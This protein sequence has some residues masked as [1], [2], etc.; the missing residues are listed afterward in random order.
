[1][2][3]EIKKKL[4]LI[5]DSSCDLPIEILKQYDITI[6]PIS[7][8]FDEE[9]RKPYIDITL[10]E[11]LNRMVE[12]KVVPI[13][14]VPPPIRFQDAFVK[15]LDKYEEAIM[16]TASKNLSGVWENA[17]IHAKQMTGNKVT[18]ID[19]RTSTH[20]FGLITLKA[21]RMIEDDLSKD[22]I[23]NKLTNEI[24]PKARLHAYMGT[25]EFLKRSGRIDNLKHMFG[26]LFKVKPL[27]T[28]ENGEITSNKRVR[29]EGAIIKY[30][31]QLGE[32]L[33]NAL[34]ETEQLVVTHSR[35]MEKAKELVYYM[36]EKSNKNLEIHI[37]EIGP[38]TG[39]HIGPGFLGLSW[40]GPAAED[41]FI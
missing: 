6:V 14:G 8:F 23:I 5:T 41:L 35:N 29:G 18:V 32:K 27:L 9:V 25:L 28:L 7:I 24:I 36:K 16:L 12:E 30:L 33:V 20:P 1:M 3:E 13:T 31:K 39:V 37:W 22:E 11:V 19:S 34:P 38:A 15:V 4:A 26:E 21:A 2:G 40:I 17:V 10:E